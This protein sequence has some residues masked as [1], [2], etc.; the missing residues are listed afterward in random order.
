[1]TLVVLIPTQ[2]GLLFAADSRTTV[3]TT[4]IEVSCDNA[5]KIFEPHRKHTAITVTGHGKF[6]PDNILRLVAPCRYIKTTLPL[7][8]IESL[9]QQ[10]LESGNGQLSQQEVLTLANKCKEAVA[11]YAFD[12]ARFKPLEPFRGNGIFRVVIGSYNPADHTFLIVTFEIAAGEDLTVQMGNFEWKPMSMEDGR[13]AMLFGE[14]SYVRQH[15]YN[16]A[17]GLEDFNAF[18]Q[19]GK[20]VKDV[21]VAEA[22]AAAVNLIEATSRRTEEIP[23]S[24]GIGGPVD[25]LLVNDK[26]KATRLR[27]KPDS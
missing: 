13:E 9:V 19:S 2:E 20:K 8:D 23:A 15:V 3:R 17:S 1:M 24:S 16:L 11:K 5:V 6:L 7:L 22:Q 26:E 27:W 21:T 4:V 18:M 12:Y 14:T 10:E 25:V